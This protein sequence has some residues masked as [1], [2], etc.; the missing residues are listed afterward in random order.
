MPHT[1]WPMPRRAWAV[2]LAAG[3]LAISLYLAVVHYSDGQ[4]PLACPSSGFINCEDVTS[5]AE[6]MLGPLPVALLGS[7]WFGV[8]LSLVA[9]PRATSGVLLAWTIAA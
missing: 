7:I 1:G 4:I 2:L 6:S 5:S 9:L 3:G 8:A